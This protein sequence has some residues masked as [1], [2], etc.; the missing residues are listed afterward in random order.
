MEK[1][2]ILSIDQGT[3]TTKVVVFDREG[4]PVTSAYHE[5]QQ[6]YPQPGWVEHDPRELWETTKWCIDQALTEKKI[7]PSEIAAIGITMQRET[8]IL[9]DR[10]TGEPLYNAIVWQCRRTAEICEDLKARG[11]EGMV[12]EKTGLVID[13]YF[14]GT[15]IK[16]ILDHI[17]EAKQK[18]NAGQLCF[19]TVDTW[20]LWKLTGGQV[21]ATDYSN[22]SRTMLFNIRE[23][24]WDDELLAMLEIPRAILPEAKPSSGVFGY[25]AP[26]LFAGE[27]I[28]IAGIAGDQHAS[29]FGQTCFK[30][31]MAKNTYGTSLAMVM[32]IGEEFKPSHNGLTTDLAWGI[33]NRIEYA[34]EGVVFIG[35]AVVQWLR[36]GLKIIDH[37]AETEKMA[38][39][40][41]D[42]GGIYIVPAFTGLCA[43]YWD[44]YARGTIVGIT[45]GTSKEHFA[46]AA[47]ESIAYQTKDVLEA[48]VA[49]SGESL[50][51]LRVDGGAVRNEFLMQ[52]QADILGVPVQRPV[53]T[54][55]AA[56]GAAYLAGLAVGFWESQE[57]LVAQWKIDKT[58]EPVMTAERREELYSGWKRAVERSLNWAKN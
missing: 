17:P 12:R 16:W 19:G 36:D 37:A 9:W 21:H 39:M 52:F 24:K 54:D 35:G 43:P 31:G 13:P 50:E 29:T 28:P 56:L 42:T 15:K 44:M 57:Q 40:V 30:P 25:T 10:S 33:D 27:R 48:M 4:T 34:F 47:L 6:I 18:A 22:A 45:R 2:Y 58:Y 20:L 55:M 3:T 26:E 46:R 23:V 11:Y 32:N 53:V 1:K 51:S 49:D 5:I 41:P 8:T 14:S 7:H 38:Q